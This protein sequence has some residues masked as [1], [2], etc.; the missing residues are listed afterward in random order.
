MKKHK[1]NKDNIYNIFFTIIFIIGFLILSYPFISD[2][3]NQHKQS[4][5]ITTYQQEIKN[6]DQEIYQ[7]ELQKVQDYNKKIYEYASIQHAYYLETNNDTYNNLL[8]LGQIGVMGILRIPII[9]VELPIYHGTSNE[10]LQVGVGHLIGSSL[11]IGGMNT[12]S[13]LTGHTGLPS[14]KLLSDAD[15]LEK[16][17]VF[18][19]DVLKET[20]AYEVVDIQSVLPDETESLNI[21]EGEDYCTIITC[22]PYGINT[23]RL[24]VTGKRVAYVDMREELR[25][26]VFNVPIRVVLLVIWIFL[27]MIY[28]VISHKKR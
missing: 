20:L 16:G 22:T 11:P 10:V 27:F 23:H 19:I 12:H 6:I 25:N 1:V 15:K 26:E 4:N 24:L 3:V 21:V 7:Q 14:S 8:D 9:D 17:D 5:I 28:F 2:L 13:V 18:Y